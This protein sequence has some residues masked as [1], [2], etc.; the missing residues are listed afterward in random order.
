MQ[1]GS[2]HESPPFPRASAS[3]ALTASPGIGHAA[4]H[5]GTFRS[6]LD[7]VADVPGRARRYAQNVATRV[8]ELD[9]PLDLARTLFP[10]RRGT[11]DPTFR[12]EGTT[13]AWAARTPDGP[14]AVTIRQVDRSR[15]EAS[16]TGPG[17]DVCL[18]RAPGTI[19]A[20]DD[21]DAF[22]P[23][24]EVMTRLA[25]AHR[26]VRLTRTTD[27]FP[28]LVAAICE[29][30]VT[31]TRARRAW[32]A[33]VRATSEPAPGDAGLW[34]PPDP[35][36]LATLP[37][38]AFH[39]AEIEARRASVI[40]E[41]ARRASSL[42]RLTVMPETEAGE[43]LQRLPGVGPWT[44]AEVRRL[45]LGDPDAISVG[46]FHVPNLV[47]WALAGEPR[48]DDARMLEL[49]EPYRGQRGRVQRLLEASEIRAP[50]WGPRADVGSIASL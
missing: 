2:T 11:G 34:L 35:E 23:R 32:R 41:V 13:A 47:A 37:S 12:I 40:R 18:G 8:I 9:G 50:R 43:A 42:E 49:L 31:G 4:R 45:A 33:L 16:A 10:I 7:G 27:V 26:G 24:D 3:L 48:A 14:A 6:W 17:A 38:F 25:R 20:L 22:V 30:K 21:P 5:A 28:A 29:Q 19:G 1:R 15:V 46:D 44:A 39:R 36:R